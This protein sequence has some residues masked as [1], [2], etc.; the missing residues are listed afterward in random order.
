MSDTALFTSC[1]ESLVT[2]GHTAWTLV[3]FRL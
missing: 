2:L 3:S 1:C